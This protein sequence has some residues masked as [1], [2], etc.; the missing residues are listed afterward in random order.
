MQRQHADGERDEQQHDGVAEPDERE[1]RGGEENAADN[2]CH[3][4]RG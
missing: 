2:T 3:V 1:E 4:G